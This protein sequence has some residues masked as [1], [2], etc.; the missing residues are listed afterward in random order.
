MSLGAT[1]YY[2]KGVDFCEDII[3]DMKRLLDEK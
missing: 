2:I 3:N 1:R